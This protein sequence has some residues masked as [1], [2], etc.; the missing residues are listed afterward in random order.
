MNFGTPSPAAD[1]PTHISRQDV[2]HSLTVYAHLLKSV[3]N[4]QR[5]YADLA[6]A[7][8]D[9]ANALEAMGQCKGADQSGHGLKVAA[10]LHRVIAKNQELFAETVHKE[11]E[12]PL[13]RNLVAHGKKTDENEKQF[14]KS[15]RKMQDEIA[16]TENRMLKGIS[17]VACCALRHA[18]ACY[19]L[20]CVCMSMNLRASLRSS[21]L[22]S[23]PR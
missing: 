23:P 17:R 14:E 4:F 21:S 12:A 8:V 5:K 7:S 3:A 1:V 9:F 10:E 20:A 19:V 15:M 22:H 2:Q 6:H 18:L 16:K 11:F 13:Q